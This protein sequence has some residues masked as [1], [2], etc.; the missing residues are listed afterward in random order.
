MV[1][2]LLLQDV[3]TV[4]YEFATMKARMDK[5]R[6]LKAAGKPMPENAMELEKAM[7]PAPS[8]A[9]KP[10]AKKVVQQGGGKAGA[11]QFTR[12]SVV[13]TSAAPSAVESAGKNAK[14][15]CNSGKKYKRCCMPQ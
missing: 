15:A 13:R 2:L 7:A 8:L 3:N 4:I 12:Q 14:C 1:K 5:M 6:E 9:E 11:Q 10:T